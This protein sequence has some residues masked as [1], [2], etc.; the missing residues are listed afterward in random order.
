VNTARGSGLLHRQF[1]A[2]ALL[3]LTLAWPGPQLLAWDAQGHRVITCLALD[4][5]SLSDVPWLAT[6][7]A[8]E[9]ILFQANEPDRR[10]SWPSPVLRHIN[11][12][13]HYLNIDDLPQFGLRLAALPRFRRD[14]LRRLVLADIPRRLSTDAEA[15]RD[16]AETLSRPGF[17]A[18]AMAEAYARLQ[19]ALHQARILEGDRHGVYDQQPRE[20]ARANVIYELGRLSHL[21]GDGSQPL[22]TTRHF[23]G[24]RGSNPGGY[25]TDRAF[26]HKVD[27][28]PGDHAAL[29]CSAL[30]AG[31]G[32]LPRPAPDDPWLDI[33]TYLEETYALVQ[34]LYHLEQAGDLDGEKGTRFTAARL[35][36]GA[37]MLAGLL[38]AALDST[39]PTAAEP[40]REQSSRNPG[41]AR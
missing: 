24:W 3:C 27:G 39:R 7:A 11:A 21:V 1:T 26:H 25:T 2:A 15:N 35:R 32:P 19:A 33:L 17:L 29:T 23:N 10:R 5:V 18:H 14:Y 28:R 31:L 40:H 38:R 12:P 9:R 4:A 30:A 37:A 34:P 8:R 6:P 20:Q 16:P 41:P 22:H 36:A 13:D